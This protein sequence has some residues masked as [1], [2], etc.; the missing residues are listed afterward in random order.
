[1]KIKFTFLII[2]CAVFVFGQNKIFQHAVS[3][4]SLNAHQKIS[5]NLASTYVSTKYYQQPS[6]DLKSDLQIVLP[7]NKEIKAQFSKTFIYSNKSESFVYTI[8][9]D[10]KAELVLSK[11]DNIVTGMYASGT[12]EKVMFHQ[13]EG[14]IF[15][16]SSVNESGLISQ[17]AKSDFIL[18][19]SGISQKVNANV[20][21]DTSPICPAT[22]IDVMVVFTPAART[23]WGGVAQSN[24]FIATAITNFNTALVNSGVSNVAINLVYAGEVAYTESGDINTDLTRFRTTNDSFMDDIHTLRATYG[25]DLCGLIT[26]TPTSTCGLGYLNTNPGNYSANSAF[27]VSIYSCVVSN[28][29]LSHEMGHNMGLNHDWYVSSSALPCEHHHGYSNQI[30]VAAGASSTN[31]QRWRTIMA[32]NDECADSGI[33]CTRINRWAN[34]SINYNGAPTGI[35]I[36][37]FNPS[38]EAY[39]F[40]RF[41]CVVSQFMPTSGLGTFEIKNNE[42]KD[43]TIYPNPAK[44]EINI[45]IKND[46]KYRFKI[47]NPVG[48]IVLTTD[49]KTINLS[50]LSSGE[51]FLSVYSEN[52]SFIG[53]KKFIIK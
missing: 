6:F 1:M 23:L 4:S 38:N 29:T 19:E 2:F 22:T 10:A 15:A 8:E 28:Y 11:Y 18:N 17:D 42:V 52:N 30:A 44:E 37:D 40:V 32:Y 14:N 3:E 24:S 33:N 26:S 51:Y 9:N 46:E 39:G 48:Q 27:T 47:I 50:G 36:G 5:T 53:S 12:G 49:K 25:A 34:P 43:F 45:W 21:L 31:S 41:A 20:C 13:T 35:P 16:V 7:D